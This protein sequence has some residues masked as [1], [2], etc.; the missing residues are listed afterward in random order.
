[1]ELV[2]DT[3]HDV[4]RSTLRSFL[5]EQCSS[6]HVRDITASAER[7]DCPL[8]KRLASDLGVLGLGV[9]ER[10]SGC[11]GGIRD[12][13]VVLGELG[14]VLAPVPLLTHALAMSAVLSSADDP[15]CVELLPALV[16]GEIV[17]AW[18]PAPGV[19]ARRGRL[20]GISAAVLDGMVADLV[21]LPAGRE[22]YAV[23]TNASGMSVIPLSTIDPTRGLARL[24]LTDVPARRLRCAEPAAV[25]EH[26]ADLAA[27][28]L[29][30]EQ[31]G[32]LTR[33]VEMTVQHA[34]VRTQFGRAIGSFQAV[35]HRCADMYAAAELAD[36]VAW[37]AAWAADEAHAELPVAAN[38]AKVQVSDAFCRVAADMVHLHGGLGFTWE[39][40]AQL[41]Y[42]RA[43]ISAQLFGSPTS[44]RFR[45]ADRLGV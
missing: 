4:L 21:V 2:S 20:S 23:H 5:A 33:C 15:A 6:Q 7:W 39:H 16:T 40:D 18:A 22:L 44:H 3:E 24:E 32:G 41:H 43:R 34:R 38:L 37:Y 42:K 19:T 28:L 10:Y 27:V 14:R 12:L 26:I 45:L 13:A 29:A 11:G 17:A 35:K 9:P 1:M 31:V 36:A 30:A 8:W 25:G